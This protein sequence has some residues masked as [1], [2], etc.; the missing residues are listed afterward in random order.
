VRSSMSSYY[1]QAHRSLTV[2]YKESNDSS[3]LRLNHAPGGVTEGGTE[4]GGGG[5]GD[6]RHH[7][8]APLNDANAVPRCGVLALD[9]KNDKPVTDQPSAG[10]H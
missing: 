6:G 10:T 5:R 4:E 8:Q 3:C 7:D 9:L 2:T 1:E